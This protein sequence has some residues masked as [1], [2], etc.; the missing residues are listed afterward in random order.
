[1]FKHLNVQVRGFVQGVSLRKNVKDKAIELNL[2]GF[3]QNQDDGSVI[4]EAEGGEIDLIEL[5][6]FIKSGPG[7]AE[8]EKIKYHFSEKIKDFSSFEIKY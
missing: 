4:I 8:P 1:M 5:F 3:V 6:E 7:M 2:Q